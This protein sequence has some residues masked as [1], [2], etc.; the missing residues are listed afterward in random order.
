MERNVRH[1]AW[2]HVPRDSF[3]IVVLTIFSWSPELRRDLEELKKDNV[4]GL[5]T[6]GYAVDVEDVS[7]S[8]DDEDDEDEL[9]DDEENST[10]DMEWDGDA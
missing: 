8:D 4:F 10:S 1:W 7:S 5:F 6:Q 9:D 3:I 2:K